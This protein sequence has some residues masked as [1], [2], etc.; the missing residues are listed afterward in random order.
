MNAISMFLME[1]RVI[2]PDFFSL[3][4]GDL[5]TRVMSTSEENRLEVEGFVMEHCGFRETDWSMEMISPP[6]I[7]E[8]WGWGL[9][10]SE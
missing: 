7:P 8:D 10:R 2:F 4:L 9:V 5:V 1:V 3:D 6:Y